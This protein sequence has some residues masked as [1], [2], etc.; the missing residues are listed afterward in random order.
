MTSRIPFLGFGGKPGSGKDAFA[1]HLI[2]RHGWV[3]VNMSKPIHELTLVVNPIVSARVVLD[4][5]R[6]SDRLPAWARRAAAW[7][8]P[9]TVEYERYADVTE[10]LGFTEAKNV[11]EY[12]RLLQDLGTGARQVISR[13]VW[14]DLAGRAIDA[15][16]EQGNRVVLS[17]VRTVDEIQLVESRG[18]QNVWV[19]RPGYDTTAA[20]QHGI[21][22]A[23]S[24]DD[25]DRVIRNDGTLEDLYV[26][27]DAVSAE[28][29][30]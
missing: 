12:R 15:E 21:E 2:A 29:D 7:F 22:T 10:R 11:P 4:I 9:R 28:F 17:G 3:K 25:F 14:V 24:A 13:K 27:A 8:L 26:Q 30:G 5:D 23:V 6:T 18:G 16:L 19:I 20:A 1:D